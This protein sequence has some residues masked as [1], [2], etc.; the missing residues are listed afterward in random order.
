MIESE[1]DEG[2][3]Y[4]GFAE[5]LSMVLAKTRPVATE[6]LPLASCPGYVSAT[7]VHAL[8]DNPPA[9]TSLKD[10]FA[11]RSRDVIQAAPQSPVE[12][13][14]VGSVFAGGEFK[15]RLFARQTVK[16]CSGAPVPD[17]ADAVVSSEFCSESRDKVLFNAG[18]NRGRNVLAAGADVRIGMTVVKTGDT[19]LPA[20]LAFLAAAGISRLNVYRKPRLAILSIG[21]ELVSPGRKL[22]EGQIYASNAVNI[23]AWLSLLNIPF[24]TAVVR[25]DTTSVRKAL[26]QLS[27][28]ADAIITSGGVMHSE[29]DLIVGIL[30]NLGWQIAF[31]HVRMGPGKGTSFGIWQNK[32]VFCLSGGPG[33]NNIAFLQLA[34]PGI[35]NMTGRSNHSLFTVSARLTQGV[36]SRHRAW[37][38]FKEA[39]LVRKKDGQFSVT[40]LSEKSRPKSGADADCL[41][42]KPEGFDSLRRGQMVTVQ[43]LMPCLES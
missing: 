41:F 3:D 26:L 33:S 6:E 35:L 27:Q 29:R 13:K 9:A 42:C 4:T 17:G 2:T 22:K 24:I 38:E 20:R 7:D 40:P 34:L 10:G 11:V 36:K 28:E 18:A 12:L 32:P 19:L 31:R 39:G 5:A 15:R 37:T 30:D 14:L 1:L 25:D 8:V 23:G 21:D 16:V 43:L